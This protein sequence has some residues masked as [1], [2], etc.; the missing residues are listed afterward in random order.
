MTKLLAPSILAADF[1]KLG[2]EIKSVEIAG[3]DIIHFDVMDGHFVPNLT[4]GPM[5]LE[6]TRRVTSLPIDAHLM[7]TNPDEVLESYIQAGANYLSVHVEVC[8]HLHRT[9]QRIRSLGVKAGV[10]LNP[11][12]S[13]TSIETVLEDL[14]YV[15]VMTVNPGFG[16]QKFIESAFQKVGQ[17]DK[18]RQERKLNFLIEVDGGVKLDN[19]AK[20]SQ[21][22]TNLFVAGSAIF[23]SEDY[24][25][26]IKAMKE[27]W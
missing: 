2:E 25:A 24:R 14:D 16:G 18:I 22:G 4:I 9:L 19:I 20:I 17:L 8:P 6:A 23:G 1:S 11:H 3:A 13:V 27:A 7:V 26:T 15:L 21:A 5:I 12:S 10:V